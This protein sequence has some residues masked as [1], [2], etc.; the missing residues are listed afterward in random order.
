MVK[1]SVQQVVDNSV[2]KIRREDFS[3]RG[4]GYNKADMPGNFIPPGLQVAQ[5]LDQVSLAVEFELQ[6]VDRVLFVRLAVLICPP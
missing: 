6:R 3:R 2:T 5:K 1:L 4:L